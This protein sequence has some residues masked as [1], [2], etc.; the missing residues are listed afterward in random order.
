M[1]KICTKCKRE[2]EIDKFGKDKTRID[3]LNVYCKECVLIKRKLFV[4]SHPNKRSEYNKSYRV[5]NPIKAQLCGANY[6]KS[7]KDKEAIRHKIYADN[8]KE[9]SEHRMLYRKKYDEEHKEVRRQYRRLHY[10]ENREKSNV[11]SHQY[12]ARKSLLISTLT[13]NQWE[14]IKSDFNNRCA[15]CNKEL[16]LA[17]EHFIAITK[18][19]EYATSNII[20]ACGSCNS[21]KGNKDFFLWYPKYKYYNKKREKIILKYLHYENHIQQFS[22]L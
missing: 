19:G 9:V 22:I 14:N 18:G 13:F 11:T 1:L 2:L 10:A 3:N 20:C 8:H 15:Y 5:N 6:R 12:R 16:P 21:S 7:N 17:Q 4:E